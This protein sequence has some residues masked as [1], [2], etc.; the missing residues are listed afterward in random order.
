MSSFIIVENL[1]YTGDFSKPGTSKGTILVNDAT[2]FDLLSVGADG[3]VLTANS[4]TSSGLEWNTAGGESLAATLVIGNTTGGTDISVTSGDSIV[5]AAGS[6]AGTGDPIPLVAGIGGTTGIGGAIT[7]TA[8]DGG[9]TSGNG[10]GITVTAGNGSDGGA[11]TITS[12][13]ASTGGTGADVSLVPGTGSSRGGNVVINRTSHTFETATTTIDSNINIETIIIPT[14]SVSYIT[15][16]VVGR[17]TTITGGAVGDS[18]VRTE[19]H[20]V[21]NIGGA[22]TLVS[23]ATSTNNDVG[24]WSSDVITSGANFLV[25]VNSGLV[26]TDIDWI[27]QSE[28]MN[29]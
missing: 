3:T 12:G 28:I 16:K 18:F 7:L 26:S 23:F 21:K 15:T 20:R 25:R 2:I 6:G 4:A 13:N 24:A 14:D 17:R 27:S 5:S 8:G 9:A 1:A 19:S 22:L 10:G 29:V 11:V